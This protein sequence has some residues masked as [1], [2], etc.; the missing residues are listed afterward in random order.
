MR[1][2]VNGW[3]SV[4]VVLLCAGCLLTSPVPMTPLA[5][6]TPVLTPAPATP[7]LTTDENAVMAGICFEA[8]YDA[9]GRVF[10]LSSAIDH[11][12]FYDLA[13]NARLCRQ[14]VTRVP[15]DF[16]SGRALIGTWSYGSGCTASHRIT[17][18]LR[19]TD[20]RTI[21]IQAR[22]ATEGDCPYELL[23][24]LWLAV[25]NAEGYTLALEIS[26]D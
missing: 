20:A 16:G 21:T 8:A 13:D 18:V 7:A 17:A 26:R 6:T 19:D 2:L 15:F 11:I 10:V 12:N 1:T 5:T 25:S 22:F 3:A 23:R 14:K 9:R 24:P 4:V